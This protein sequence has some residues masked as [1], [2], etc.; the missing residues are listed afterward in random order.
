MRDR[1]TREYIVAELEYDPSFEAANIGVTVEDG[2]T[3]L[4]GHVESY[5]QKSAAVAAAR[6]VAGVRAIADE[7]EVRHPDMKKHADD[8]IASRALDIIAW[9]TTLPE[10]AIIVKV[11]RGWVTLSG[12]VP[13]HFQR[14]AAEDA[15]KR[16][17]GVVGV[18]N[19]ISVRPRPE[20]KAIAERIGAALRRNAEIDAQALRVSVEGGRVALDGKVRSLAEREIAETTAWSAQGVEHVD[21]H[22]LVG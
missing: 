1:W 16:L 3:T 21:N 4:F 14:I 12:S 15:V 7:I 18:V 2:I 11:D 10:G 6:R 8:Q 20:K 5:A 9:D 19:L 13:W 17:G 22:L